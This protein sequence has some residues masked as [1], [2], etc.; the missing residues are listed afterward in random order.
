VQLFSYRVVL[1]VSQGKNICQKANRVVGIAR[2]FR[3]LSGSVQSMV[4][5]ERLR[6][7]RYTASRKSGLAREKDPNWVRSLPS[8]ALTAIS[9]LVSLYQSAWVA[10]FP[11]YYLIPEFGTMLI[12]TF[13]REGASDTATK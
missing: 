11:R 13:S 8:D 4:R 10:H 6:R 1:K 2:F 5:T 7:T 9:Q 3:F 12:S